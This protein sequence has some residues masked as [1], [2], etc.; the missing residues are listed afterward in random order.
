MFENI[1]LYVFDDWRAGVVG[2]IVAVLW[3]VIF[4]GL[5]YAQQRAKLA[6][7][8]SIWKPLLQHRRLITVVLTT[9]PS[10]TPGGTPK[11]SLSEV[12]AFS[13]LQGTLQSLKLTPILSHRPNC[14]LSEIQGHVISIGGP[15]ANHV[16]QEILAAIAQKHPTMP[17]YDDAQGGCIAAG[18]QRYETQYAPDRTLIKDYGL[19]IRTT[20][21]QPDPSA[22][23]FVAFALRGRATWGAVKAVTVDEALKNSINSK[24][25]KEDFVLVLEF[26]FTNNEITSTKIISLQPY[27][28]I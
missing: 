2:T 16:T 18:P 14:H 8:R 11:A 24:V 5:K 25:G 9:K 28:E 13:A 10:N 6:L 21:L 1:R 19:V 27:K 23:Y 22:C 3:N 4:A 20:G 17:T 26:I 12:E 15:K 7:T